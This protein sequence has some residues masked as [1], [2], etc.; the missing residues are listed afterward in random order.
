MLT[1]VT[2]ARSLPARSIMDNF[3][4]HISPLRRSVRVTRIWKTVIGYKQ[5]NTVKHTGLKMF[6]SSNMQARICEQLIVII[7]TILPWE[8]DDSAFASVTHWLRLRLP[9]DT[10]SNTWRQYTDRVITVNL[11]NCVLADWCITYLVGRF[12]LMKRETCNHHS[13]LSG[14][15]KI[16]WHLK[17]EN[18]NKMSCVSFNLH[19]KF[20]G[21]S[22]FTYQV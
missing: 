17:R 5:L 1:V 3:P 15:T 2:A 14:F 16:K 12:R 19:I 6:N 10:K 13:S 9:N 20:N 7:I 22:T 8:R 18:L 11:L 21:S 4:V